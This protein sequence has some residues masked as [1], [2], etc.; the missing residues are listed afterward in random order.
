MN[1]AR[2]F[3]PYIAYGDFTYFWIYVLGPI[4]GMMAGAVAYQFTHD[5]RDS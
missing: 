1:P 2:A 5:D 4:A 3:G